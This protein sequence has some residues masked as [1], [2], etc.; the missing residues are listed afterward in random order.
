M[1]HGY[2]SR[3]EPS[4]G[5]GWLV[6]EAG[7]DWF[8]VRDGVTTALEHLSVDERVA[9]TAEWTAHGPRAAA[10]RPAHLLQVV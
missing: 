6:D 8:F 4:H 5:F 10:V 3:V 9:F 7:M 2:I 1:L